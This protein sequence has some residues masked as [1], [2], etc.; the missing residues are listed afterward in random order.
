MSSIAKALDLIQGEEQAYFGCLL[1]TLV[2]TMLK[3]KTTKENG[4]VGSMSL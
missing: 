3:L 2:A 4:L 1:P